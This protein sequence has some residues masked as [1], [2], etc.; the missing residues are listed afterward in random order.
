MKLCAWYDDWPATND[1]LRPAGARDVALPW[2]AVAHY[3]S[4]RDV[5]GAALTTLLTNAGVTLSAVELPPLTCLSEAT[6]E[7]ETDD[8]YMRM[9]IVERLG[10]PLAIVAS[11][12][13]G[14]VG[15]P[16]MRD[17]LTRLAALAERMDLRLLVRNTSGSA[18]ATPEA[19]DE[20]FREVNSPALGFCLDVGE[21]DRAV[22]NPAEL[23]LR[24]ADGLSAV[25]APDA[26][27]AGTRAPDA[28]FGAVVEELSAEAY[29]GLLIA[30]AGD[31]GVL[32]AQY[33]L[34]V[35]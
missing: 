24:Y 3:V 26:S 28:H 27:A 11:G 29:D 19:L 8:S 13:A 16:M 12:H 1:P 17:A 9:Q 33:G 20:L 34:P 6:F 22:I 30:R 10:A 35:T 5:S 7:Q 31:I 18:L 23:V 4:H 15:L 14:E 32:V 25:V 21:C 2:S